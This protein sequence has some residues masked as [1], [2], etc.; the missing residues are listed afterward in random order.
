MKKYILRFRAVNRKNFNEIK[1]GLKSVETRAA[2]VRYQDIKKGDTL[3]IVC[4]KARI[5]KQ[6]KRVRRFKTIGSMFKA[7]PFKKVS[8]SLRTAAQARA[9]FY[10]YPGYREKIK[11]F[12]LVALDIS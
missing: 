6:V 9:V 3:V 8:P 10:G 4:G 7:I 12:G 11:E 2:T 1:D 5:T